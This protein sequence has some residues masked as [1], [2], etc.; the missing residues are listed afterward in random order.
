MKPFLSKY[1]FPLAALAALIAYLLCHFQEKRCT[2]PITT[3][4]VRSD[5][6]LI[7]PDSTIAGVTQVK[8]KV[9]TLDSLGATLLDTTIAP[10]QRVVSPPPPE[11]TTVRVAQDYQA[12]GGTIVTTENDNFK[13]QGG[14]IVVDVVIRDPTP[15]ESAGFTNCC[16][17]TSSLWT[18]LN[19]VQLTA[20]SPYKFN[21][22][23]YIPTGANTAKFVVT[24]NNNGTLTTVQFVVLYNPSLLDPDNKP[25]I[26]GPCSTS[27]DGTGFS[28]CDANMTTMYSVPG[29]NFSIRFFKI[30]TTSMEIEIIP[31]NNGTI[32]GYSCPGPIG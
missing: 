25:I 13:L 3:Y 1:F 24:A 11:N 22:D 4:E 21:W 14:I 18:N 17:S 19:N 16:T 9:T 20:F 5:G 2:D 23:P 32:S 28:R 29:L 8:I 26:L 15:E 10:G 6:L 31:Q 30:G 12:A 7:E 27:G